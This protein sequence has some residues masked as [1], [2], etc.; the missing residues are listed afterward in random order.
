MHKN[1]SDVHLSTFRK[2]YLVRKVWI[3]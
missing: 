2:E 3:L 1:T